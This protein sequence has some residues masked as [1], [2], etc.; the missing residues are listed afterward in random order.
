MRW[1]VFAQKASDECAIE[2]AQINIKELL[3]LNRLP[4]A[5]EKFLKKWT[6]TLSIVKYFQ[7]NK[8][9]IHH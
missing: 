1:R 6:V 7:S 2:H 5:K 8:S 3:I 4:L 9:I